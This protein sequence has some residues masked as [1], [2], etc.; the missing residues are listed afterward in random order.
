MSERK[1]YIV[2][3]ASCNCYAESAYVDL[4]ADELALLER[5][6]RSLDKWGGSIYVSPAS[7]SEEWAVEAAE[8]NAR[9]NA[10]EEPS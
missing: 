7:D 6:D 2:T 3:V 9:W 10:I 5:V 8:R 1:R 4:T